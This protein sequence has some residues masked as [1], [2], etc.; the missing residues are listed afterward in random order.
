MTGAPGPPLAGRVSFLLSQLGARSAQEFASRLAPLGIRP[1]HFGVL[2]HL[3][4]DEGQS[5]Q[6]LADVMGIHRNVMV[7]L[8]DDLEDR[9]LIERRR[10]P[11]DR[12]AHAIHLT[13]AAHD[14]LPRAQRVA[15][16]QETQLL[17]GIDDA[18][19]TH[20]ITLLRRLAE[21]AGLPPGVHPRLRDAE[22]SP[23][24]R[25]C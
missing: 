17:A 23:A 16:E 3:S 10:Q 12:R 18:D 5:Q 7:G 4:R 11:T 2:M 15:D 21:H 20:L 25:P 19:R 24:S 8:I 9:G 14:L 22:S 6:Q 1:S 13:E